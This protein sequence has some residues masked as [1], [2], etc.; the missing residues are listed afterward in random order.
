MGL[1]EGCPGCRYLRTGQVRQQAHSEACR[2]RIE[3][4]SRK[5][6]RLDPHDW[7][8]LTE[9]PT[10]QW[11]MQLNYSPTK[12]PGMRGTLKRTSVGHPESESRKKVALDT[13]QDLT[14]TSFSLPRRIISIRC[15]TQRHHKHRPERQ[16][17]RRDERGENKTHK[18]QGSRGGGVAMEGNSEDENSPRHPNP[19]GSDSRRRI[20]TKREPR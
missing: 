8:R 10:V 18:Q 13:E 20:T 9:E 17:E 19:S 1:S 6:T 5:A 16:H 7:L 3:S 11:L 12:D 2:K 14:T 4:L 15:T